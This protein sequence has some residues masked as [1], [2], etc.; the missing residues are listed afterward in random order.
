MKEEGQGLWSQGGRAGTA[1]RQL[2]VYHVPVQ[3]H[4]NSQLLGVPPHSGYAVLEAREAEVVTPRIIVPG[5]VK[6]M[7]PDGPS[8]RIS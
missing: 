3:R 4:S 5:R 8:T 1:E 2:N 7:A 6:A